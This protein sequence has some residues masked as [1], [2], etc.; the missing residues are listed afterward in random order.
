MKRILLVMIL[1]VVGMTASYSMELR[2]YNV[3]YK[4]S[5]RNTFR[6]LVKYL[7]ADEQQEL[8]LR[9]IFSLTERKLNYANKKESVIDAEKALM[10]NLGNA[11]HIL[12]P[13][14]YRKYLIVLNVSKHSNYEEY[15]AVNK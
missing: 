15:I 14:Q 2:E 5:D 9:Y 12:T 6:A 11:K 3:L 13:D 4:V 10:F 1:A 8:Q 7:N